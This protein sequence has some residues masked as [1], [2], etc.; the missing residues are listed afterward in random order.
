ML[1]LRIGYGNKVCLNGNSSTR[2]NQF[3]P[4]NGVLMRERAG[5]RR[6]LATTVAL[7]TKCHARPDV[8]TVH[9]PA[10]ACSMQHMQAHDHTHALR[11]A[12]TPYIES[13]SHRAWADEQRCNKKPRDGQIVGMPLPP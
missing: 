10:S 4:V 12:P 5:A 9:V 3:V 2:G 11:Y 7:A 1:L 8:S 6:H 13:S